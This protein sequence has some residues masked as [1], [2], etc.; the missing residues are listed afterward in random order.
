MSLATRARRIWDRPVAGHERRAALTVVVVLLAA[1]TTLLAATRPSRH[2]AAPQETTTSIAKAARSP[3]PAGRPTAAHSARVAP[4][5]A[6]VAHRFLT[7]YLAYLYGHAPAA[8]LTD[9]VPRLVRA[10]RARPPLV[11]PAMRARHPRL[12]ALRPMPAPAGMVGI[13]A[14]VNDGELADYSIGLLLGREHGRLLVDA[15]ESAS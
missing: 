1:S 2:R 7:G 13:S 3:T 5:A 4:V 10:L 11:P 8:A 15:V 9:A 6:R 12:L 14:L